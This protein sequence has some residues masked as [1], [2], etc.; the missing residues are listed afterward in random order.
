MKAVD[1]RPV[2]PEERTQPALDLFLIFAAANIVATTFVTGSSLVP[3]FPVRQ[4]LALIAAGSVLGAGLV[5][6]LAPVGNRLGVPSVI[7]ARAA[8]G[9]RGASLLALLLYVTNFAWIAL[10]NV[11]AATACARAFGPQASERAWAVALGLAATAVVS[12]GPRAVGLADR[13]AV[14]LM[15]AAGLA[16]AWRLASQPLPDG[17]GHGTG[18]SAWVGLD[19]VVGYQVS[20]I[21]MFADYSRYTP[22]ARRGALAVFLGLGLSSLWL[23]STGAL[24]SAA[25]GSGDP[26]E[27]IENLG[28]GAAGAGIL[29]LASL[30]TNFVNIYLSALAWKSVF[31]RARDTASI[32]SIG[33]VGAVLSLFS[34]EWLTGYADFMLLLGSVLVPAGG[35]LLARFLLLRRPVAVAALYDESG[36]HRGF[37]A[38][39]LLA[40]ALG[41]VAYHAAGRYG[42]TLPALLTAVVAYA[43]LSAARTPR[44]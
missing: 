21:L 19:V 5:A 44:S 6:A 28:L 8:L 15:A 14:P 18:M 27:L 16:L 12:L 34:R 33:I 24:L 37:Q 35:V 41:A 3:A 17:A 22:S 40:W 39:G 26:A 42:S 38:A 23:M 43:A 4:A 31:P 1:T 20:W 13:V 29:A 30:T 7:A 9:I 32:W 36:P 2:P 25:V 10:N 11:I